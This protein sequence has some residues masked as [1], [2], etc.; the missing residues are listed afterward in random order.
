MPIAAILAN[1]FIA[2]ATQWLAAILVKVQYRRH[3]EIQR[4]AEIQRRFVD[5]LSHR[6]DGSNRPSLSLD[7]AIGAAFTGR[8]QG[9]RGE[10][11]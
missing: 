1:R 5:I 9:A 11:P 7:E 6:I 4:V 2:I 10:N 3:V 8:S